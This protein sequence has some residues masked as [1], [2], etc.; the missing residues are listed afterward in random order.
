MKSIIV[1]EKNMN[2][3]YFV[4]GRPTEFDQRLCYL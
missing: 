2:L 3:L 4:S 1:F